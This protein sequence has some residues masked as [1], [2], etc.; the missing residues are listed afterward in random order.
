M[1]SSSETNLSEEQGTRQ[2]FV[3]SVWQALSGSRILTSEERTRNRNAP[4]F[5]G[6]GAGTANRDVEPTR[7]LEKPDVKP[8][9]PKTDTVG[10]GEVSQRES[11]LTFYSDRQLGK[12]LNSN[13]GR[14]AGIDFVDRSSRPFSPP[15]HQHSV[16]FVSERGFAF[17]DPT[18]SGTQGFVEPD[19]RQPILRQFASSEG[20]SPR[21]GQND[22]GNITQ[23]DV[24][25]PKERS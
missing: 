1:S 5:E 10:T 14:Q 6:E 8:D 7:F 23:R 19:F 17:P 22:E 11:P 2:G 12:E 16:G 24:K 18:R 20:P 15:S 4:D 13:A 21:L 9:E 25:R 3:R